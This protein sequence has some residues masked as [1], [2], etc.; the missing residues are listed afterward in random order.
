MRKDHADLASKMLVKAAKALV[1]LPAEEMTMSDIIRTVDVATKLE[2]LS[3]GE[4]TEL[5]EWTTEHRGRVEIVSDPY[6]GLTTE[7]LRRLLNAAESEEL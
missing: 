5:T 2:R 1:A 4:P 3:R 6:D 7:E